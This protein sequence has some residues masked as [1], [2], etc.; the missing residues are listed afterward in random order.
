MDKRKLV[1]F[2]EQI[3]D[4]DADTIEKLIIS[5]NDKKLENGDYSL[6]CFKLSIT[7]PEII[8][9]I[10]SNLFTQTI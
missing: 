10:I 2:I 1:E 6:P 9:K 4:Q 8:A 3:V 5:N 7:N